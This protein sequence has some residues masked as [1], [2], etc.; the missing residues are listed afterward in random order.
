MAMR[1]LLKFF[2][3]IIIIIIDWYSGLGGRVVTLGPPGPL[4]FLQK[5]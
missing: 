4:P 2:D 1:P 3:H 5:V